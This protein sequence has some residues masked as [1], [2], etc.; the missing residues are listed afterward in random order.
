M[1]AI[2]CGKSLPQSPAADESD[3]PDTPQQCPSAIAGHSNAYSYM[4]IPWPTVETN[5]RVIVKSELQKPV[6]QAA[7]RTVF[8]FPSGSL[9]GSRVCTTDTTGTCDFHIAAPY[10][11]GW[12]PV[13]IIAEPPY[14]FMDTTVN[15]STWYGKCP[16]TPLTVVPVVLVDTSSI[17]ATL[18]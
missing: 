3:E 13:R 2:A 16:D 15:A 17:G 18:R 7:I 4:S 10:D 8:T 11:P 9:I 6:N 5:L 12:L 1:L 14:P